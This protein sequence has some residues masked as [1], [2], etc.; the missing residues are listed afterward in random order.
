MHI[1][2]KGISTKQEE[3]HLPAKDDLGHELRVSGSGEDFKNSSVYSKSLLPR[4][5]DGRGSAS[6]Y[7]T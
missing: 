6:F 2:T 3:F 4:L 1:T 7:S 5:D